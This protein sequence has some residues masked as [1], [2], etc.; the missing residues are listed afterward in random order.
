MSD[1][2]PAGNE[3]VKLQFPPPTLVGM[4]KL[5][6]SNAQLEAGVDDGVIVPNS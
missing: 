6:L 5:I 4:G 2:A 3:T 1:G